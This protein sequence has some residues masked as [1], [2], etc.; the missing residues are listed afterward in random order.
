MKQKDKKDGFLG[1]LFVPFAA[2][3]LGILIPG[4]AVI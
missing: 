3:L 2:S 4:K 1:I